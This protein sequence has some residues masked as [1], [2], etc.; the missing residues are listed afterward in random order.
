MIK[1]K[2]NEGERVRIAMRCMMLCNN[3]YVSS[4]GDMII[5]T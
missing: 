3:A 4:E 2:G 5:C 1:D